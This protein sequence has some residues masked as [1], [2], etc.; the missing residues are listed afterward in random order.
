[1]YNIRCGLFI[2][3][4]REYW[5]ADQNKVN[6]SKRLISCG[7]HC[8]ECVIVYITVDV[9]FYTDSSYAETCILI[10]RRKKMKKKNYLIVLCLSLMMIFSSLYPV[11][12]ATD[13]TNKLSKSNYNNI[14]KLTKRFINPA[15]YKVQ[16]EL[17]RN[18]SKIYKFDTDKK[19]RAFVKL[20]YDD[21]TYK[22]SAS[23]I[24]QRVF[25]KKTKNFEILAG[26]WGEDEPVF[27]H[28]KI[29]KVNSSKYTV[30]ADL[31][32]H[33][34][35]T[36]KKTKEGTIQLNIKKKKGSYYGYVATSIKIKKL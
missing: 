14:V 4:D 22:W 16:Y 23:T 5:I 11:Q 13:V 6:R 19:R 1:M 7:K 20:M 31:Y 10:K 18:Q 9:L 3:G 17:K 2:F 33:D 36:N 29:Y 25:G 26:D 30:K 32:F 35:S 24:S 27:Y 12:A 28:Y 21:T 15:G 8:L 34:W